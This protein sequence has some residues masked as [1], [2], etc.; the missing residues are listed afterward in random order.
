M[1]QVSYKHG[2]ITTDVPN[3]GKVKGTLETTSIGVD[4]YSYM[5]IPFAEPP[6]GN[7]RLEVSSLY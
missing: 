5:G 6:I 3:L 1:F 4:F 7:L 2:S